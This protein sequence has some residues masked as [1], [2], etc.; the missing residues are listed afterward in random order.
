MAEMMVPGSAPPAAPVQ[1]S[2]ADGLKMSARLQLLDILRKLERILPI[3][4]AAT[5][6][7]RSV[8]TAMRALATAVPKDALDEP[9]Q[10]V[11][12]MAGAGQPPPQM[13]PGPGGLPTGVGG[14]QPRMMGG[15]Y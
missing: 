15:G 3:L 8:L 14:P 2:P 1:L 5:D 10:P 9:D 13:P 4:G 11:P 6:E 12:Q 7:G